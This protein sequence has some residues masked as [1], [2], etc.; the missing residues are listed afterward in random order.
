MLKK[1]PF[2]GS[3]PVI[4]YTHGKALIECDNKK[5]GTRPSTWFYI[6]TDSIKK[7]VTAWNRREDD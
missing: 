2:C 6:E 1:C 5:C 4:R 3:G 7:L